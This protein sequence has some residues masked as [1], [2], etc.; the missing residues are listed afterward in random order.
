[1][2]MKALK[3]AWRQLKAQKLFVCNLVHVVRKCRAA[4]ENT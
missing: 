4:R 3:Q 1:M 2:T